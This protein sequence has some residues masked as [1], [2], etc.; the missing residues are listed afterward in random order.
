[1]KALPALMA[2][3]VE[4]ATIKAWSGPAPTAQPVQQPNQAAFSAMG[5]S[6]AASAQHAAAQPSKNQLVSSQWPTH[7]FVYIIRRPKAHSHARVLL[8]AARCEPA[9][10]SSQCSWK[11]GLTDNFPCT[12]TRGC[13]VKIGAGLQ[14]AGV[15]QAY[16]L[17]DLDNDWQALLNE[18]D[19]RLIMQ[20]SL[21]GSC[22][23]M[24]FAADDE[25]DLGTH[26]TLFLGPLAYE[27]ACLRR[28]CAGQAGHG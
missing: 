18:L 22:W 26:V 6:S 10:W 24:Y 12:T 27:V 9:L 15:A 2:S 21:W 1:M 5:A 23:C 25:R 17:D 20:V 13:A 28:A 3:N 4:H 16:A 14:A 11:S 19:D 8:C 7:P